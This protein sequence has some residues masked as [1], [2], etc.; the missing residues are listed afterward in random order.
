LMLSNECLYFK[1]YSRAARFTLSLGG[2][3]FIILMMW[4][5]VLLGNRI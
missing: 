5:A 3:V 1:P 2:A 4:G